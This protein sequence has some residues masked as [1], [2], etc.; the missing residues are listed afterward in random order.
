M[1]SSITSLPPSMQ[2]GQR[3]VDGGQGLLRGAEDEV[4]GWARRWLLH[5]EYAADDVAELVH[6]G[7]CVMPG[8]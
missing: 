4:A 7:R 2:V 1:S 6:L 3:Q 8:M 5:I